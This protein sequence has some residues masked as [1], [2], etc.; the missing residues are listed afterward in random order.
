M[1]GICYNYYMT[2]KSEPKGLHLRGSLQMDTAERVLQRHNVDSKALKL[3]VNLKDLF[4]KIPE[5][6]RTGRSGMTLYIAD[7]DMKQDLIKSLELEL[8]RSDLDDMDRASYEEM[9][10][11]QQNGQR[12][13]N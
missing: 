5:H 8:Q 13:L 11:I 7:A 1:Q 6:Q 12:G 10:D 3:I 4:S 2:E 9:L